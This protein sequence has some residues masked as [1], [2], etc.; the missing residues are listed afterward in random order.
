MWCVCVV[1]C[2]CTCTL[3]VG[4]PRPSH[5][6]MCCGLC[7]WCVCGKRGRRVYCVLVS[8]LAFPVSCVVYTKWSPDTPQQG[9]KTVHNAEKNHNCA[10]AAGEAKCPLSLTLQRKLARQC[11]LDPAGVLLCF[12][13]PLNV[14]AADRQLRPLPAT[15]FWHLA[16]GRVYVHLPTRTAADGTC[17]GHFTS[18]SCSFAD[19][20]QF[21]PD[22]SGTPLLMRFS[23]SGAS[24]S[25]KCSMRVYKVCSF[26]GNVQHST[27]PTPDK[28]DAVCTDG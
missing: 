15:R 14:L 2:P 19:N 28:P 8:M 13:N 4:N 18:S 3:R 7:C 21:I 10:G 6:C 9:D 22:I 20:G 11:H 25:G 26:G 1:V 17:N 24:E 5:P 23:G 16:F 27:G 12:A